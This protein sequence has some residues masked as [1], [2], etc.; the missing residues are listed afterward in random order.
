MTVLTNALLTD[1]TMHIFGNVT[2]THT[3]T[4]HLLYIHVYIRPLCVHMQ[5]LMLIKGPRDLSD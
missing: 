1:H 5:H 4:H 2:H 3:H